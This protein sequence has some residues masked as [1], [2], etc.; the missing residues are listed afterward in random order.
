MDILSSDVVNLVFWSMQG[1]EIVHENL[2]VLIKA[3]SVK[4]CVKKIQ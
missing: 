4:R 3:F 2:S 1:G